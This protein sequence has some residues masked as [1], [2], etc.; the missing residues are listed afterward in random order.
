MQ[1]YWSGICGL[2]RG[3]VASVS[4]CVHYKP[5]IVHFA[6]RERDRGEGCSHCV[7]EKKQHMEVCVT[8]YITKHPAYM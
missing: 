4:Y 2:K 7:M 5:L 8:L 3:L 6:Y 1:L